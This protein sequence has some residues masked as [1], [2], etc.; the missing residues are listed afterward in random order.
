MGETARLPPGWRWH[1]ATMGL[2]AALSVLFIGHGASI[3]QGVFGSGSDPFQFVWFLAWYPW[4]IAHHQSLLYTHLMWQPLGVPLLWVSSVP[5]LCLVLMPAT[6]LAGPVAVYNVMIL[7]APVLSATA[8]YFLCLRVS[9]NRVAALFGGYVFGFSSYEMAMDL[10]T[11]NLSYTF[12]L[13]CLVLLALRRLSGE[14]GRRAAVGLAVLMMVLEFFISIELFATFVFFGVCAWLLAYRVFSAQRPELRLLLGDAALAGMLT[15]VL[16]S[17]F[18]V[19]MFRHLH[20][21]NIP[22]L[23]PYYFVA[24][25]LNFIVPTKLT[26]VGGAWAWPLAKHFPGILQEQG[27]YIGLPL[28]LIAYAFAR[29]Y[30][31][32]PVTVFLAVLLVGF[33]VA[34]LGP[35]L[36]AGGHFLGAWLPWALMLHLP[37]ISSALPARFAVFVSLTCAIILA[38]WIAKAPGQKIRV[39][40]GLLTCIVLLPAPHRWTKL[41]VSTFFAPG[42]VQA[43]LGLQPRL[44]VLPFGLHGA[45][46]F[47]QAENHFGF[48]EAGGYLGFP[49]APMQHFAA[50]WE[51]EGNVQARTFPADLITFCAQTGTQ[52]VVAG[53]STPA[54]LLTMLDGLRWPRRQVDDVVVYNVPPAL[55]G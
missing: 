29:A 32:E 3:T 27:T 43:Q 42:E 6:L 54:V 55:H 9:R 41:P 30:W 2:Y 51:L 44:L 10:A 4:A 28:A 19:E 31:R 14:T 25:P 11:P 5:L 24:D 17:P 15:L 21:V 36:W 53:P 48:S 38:F 20:Y 12:L 50:I 23:W 16:L 22:K 52:Y 26:L 13:P 46:T 1:L 40:A 8:A 39:A 33:M 49:P 45:S 35:Q 18:L 34:S 7:V 37:L 47:W